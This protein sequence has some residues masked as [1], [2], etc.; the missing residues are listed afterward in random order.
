MSPVDPEE[1]Q[2]AGD[3]WVVPAFGEGAD[4][5]VRVTVAIAVDE[6]DGLQDTDVTVELLADG[7]ALTVAEQPAAGP[8]PTIGLAGANAYALYRF[9]NPDR[10]TPATVTVTVRG[11]TAAFDVSSPVA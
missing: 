1:P 3:F 8:L 9:D 7:T 5:S 4:D 10:L 11:G 2:A 6:S